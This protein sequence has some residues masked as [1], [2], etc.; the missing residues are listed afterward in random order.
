MEGSRA[1]IDDAFDVID[2]RLEQLSLYIDDWKIS[3]FFYQSEKE[4][5]A[6][7]FAIQDTRFTEYDDYGLIKSNELQFRSVDD[8]VVLTIRRDNFPDDI[9]YLDGKNQKHKIP[10]I[11]TVE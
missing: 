8:S 11:R 1:N 9:W 3:D 5:Q 7:V 6:H 2:D 4:K 10:F